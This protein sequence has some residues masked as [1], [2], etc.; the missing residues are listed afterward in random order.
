MVETSTFSI[1]TYSLSSFGIIAFIYKLSKY[2]RVK[3]LSKYYFKDKTILITGASSGLGKA[4]AE[5]FYP[6][7][8]QVI[9]CARNKDELIKLKNSLMKVNN[10][11]KNFFYFY[12]TRI[13]L[14]FFYRNREKS[15]R[16]YA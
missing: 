13:K 16:Y 1:L 8:A 5:E 10:F 4:I 14:F 9:L 15:P 11:K 7:G 3:K 12:N 6:L 2:I